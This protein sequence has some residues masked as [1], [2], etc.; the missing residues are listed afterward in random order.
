MKKRVAGP[1]APDQGR[2]AELEAATTLKPDDV[3]TQ[4][5]YGWA[6]YGHGRFE[7]AER[8]FVRCTSIAP[9]EPDV[10]Y[11]AGLVLKALGR[12]EAALEEFDRAADVALRHPDRVRGQMLH[13][14][15]VGHANFLRSGDWNLE[16][17]VWRR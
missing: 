10:H 12:K 9:G 13:R 5:E 1:V 2:I 11:G 3:Q 7:E 6:L 15:A 4:L 14:M 17:E 16:K 8:A